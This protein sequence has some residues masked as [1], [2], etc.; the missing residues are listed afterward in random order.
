MTKQDVVENAKCDLKTFLNCTYSFLT[1]VYGFG[2]GFSVAD[3]DF[4]YRIRIFWP[5]RIRK[6]G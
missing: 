4:P 3:P 5:I 1:F 6:K 2:S